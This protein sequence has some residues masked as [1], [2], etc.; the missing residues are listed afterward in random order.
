[1]GGEVSVDYVASDGSAT[2]GSDYTASSGT[3]NWASGDAADKMFTVPVN[4]D[5]RAEGT[6]TMNVSLFEPGWW[7]R[8]RP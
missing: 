8:P 1:M 7:L 5:G 2:A 3:L 4:W 6:E